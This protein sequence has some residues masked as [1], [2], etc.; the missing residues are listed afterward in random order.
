VHRGW[1]HLRSHRCRGVEE[2]LERANGLLVILQGSDKEPMSLGGCVV[3]WANISAAALD[4]ELVYFCRNDNDL[5]LQT[6]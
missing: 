2:G 3:T 1:N 5:R 4:D 6:K